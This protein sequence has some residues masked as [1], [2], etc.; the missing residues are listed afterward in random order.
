MALPRAV[1]FD[2]H[3]MIAI[4]PAWFALEVRQLPGMVLHTLA[5]HG[6]LPHDGAL[7]ARVT[8][9]YRALRI[10]IQDHGQE[11]DA[12]AGVQHA[13]RAIGV[14]VSDD[15]VVAAIDELMTSVRDGA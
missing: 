3:D 2:F 12:L 13:F 7:M 6:V 11:S 10:A 4:A 14:D 5:A 15:A 9:P 1:T 8:D